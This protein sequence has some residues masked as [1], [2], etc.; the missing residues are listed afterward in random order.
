MNVCLLIQDPELSE[1]AGRMF[2]S[3]VS[4]TSAHSCKDLLSR[5]AGSPETIAIVAA[6]LGGGPWSDGFSAEDLERYAFIVLAPADA[7][8][9]EVLTWLRRGASDVVLASNLP[10]LPRAV[11]RI[12]S[13]RSETHRAG[14]ERERLIAAAHS[15]REQAAAERRFRDLLEAA[16]DG[17]IEVDQQGRI[18]LANVVAAALF[19]YSLDELKQKRVDDLVPP[20]YRDAHARH[21]HNYQQRPAARPMGSGLALSGLRKDGSHFPVEISLSPVRSPDGF[22][23]LAIIRDVTE[24]R[25]EEERIRAMQERYTAELA[26]K[27]QELA[28]RNREI[29]RAD[30]LKSEFLASM[31]H[32]LRTPLHTIIGFTELLL[33]QVEGPL[34]PKQQRFLTHIHND[35]R[36]LLEL[37]NDILDLSKIEAG[38]VE[39]KP[40]WFDLAALIQEA[41]ASLR[42]LAD[43]K[44]LLLGLDL[45][46]ALNMRGDRVRVRE[47]L[48]NLLSNAIKFTPEGGRIVVS[49]ASEDGLVR[50]AVEDTG[51]GIPPEEHASIFDKFHQVGATTKGVREGTGLGLAIT[52]RLVEMHGGTITVESEPGRGSRF[53]V[54]LPREGPAESEQRKAA[55]DRRQPPLVLVVED[56]ASARELLATYLVPHGYEVVTASTADDA[57]AKALTLR[58]DA[59]TLD[60][61]LGGEISWRVFDVLKQSPETQRVPV[62]VVSVFEETE[63]AARR[64]VAD[65]LVKPVSRETL[66]ASLERFVSRSASTSARSMEK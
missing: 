9:H 37:I 29:E 20:Q 8:A 24:R 46:P 32:E 2:D 54:T 34:T 10:E 56:D 45:P 47:I 14:R 48:S 35:S 18:V 13:A 65:Y 16:P 57:I 66:L 27:N 44:R 59:I 12:C 1:R 42:P 5:L 21:R 28:L 11:E 39:L 64:G 31:S 61:Q 50:F 23:V 19:G 30:R 3:G 62:I 41:V 38:R 4:V 25:K 51:V 6:R 55:P 7:A 52:K 26:A 17:I 36:H 40:E 63:E 43:N 60:L 15:A 58:P 33:E 22:R 53:S 49:G